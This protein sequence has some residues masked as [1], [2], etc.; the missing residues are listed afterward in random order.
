MERICRRD[1]GLFPRPSEIRFSCS[2]PDFADMCKH[3][4]AVLYGVGVRLDEN[5]E[6]LFRLRAVNENDLLAHLE[7]GA[8]L[9]MAS[10]AAGR[11]LGADDLSSLF[12]L[13]MADDETPA[14]VETSP[15]RKAGARAKRAG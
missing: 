12:G 6:L 10:P 5:P 14:E 15:R 1:E 2:C 8:P 13:E 9:S 11:A 4:A 3:V 7:S